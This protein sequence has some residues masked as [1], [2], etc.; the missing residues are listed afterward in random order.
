MR[1][2]RCAGGSFAM[3]A[4]IRRASS[5]V[6][7]DRD[8]CRLSDS[9]LT[10]QTD[11]ESIFANSSANNEATSLHAWPCRC[12]NLACYSS[13]SPKL[14]LVCIL[15]WRTWWRHELRVHYVSTMPRHREWDR[16]LLPAKYA[17]SASARTASANENSKAS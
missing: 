3:F 5:W 16:R 12:G 8:Q 6:P 13:Q 14:S 4:A 10:R 2:A 7:F 15:R 17:I 9:R 11:E 1:F